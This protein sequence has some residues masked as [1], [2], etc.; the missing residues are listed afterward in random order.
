MRPVVLTDDERIDAWVKKVEVL[1]RDGLQDFDNVDRLRAL[2]CATQGLVSCIAW[3]TDGV[4]DWET[5][6]SVL[7]DFELEMREQ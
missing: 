6:M 4:F 3:I 5:G 1:A 2:V 7:R